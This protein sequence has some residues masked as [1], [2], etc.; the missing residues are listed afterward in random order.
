MTG[1]DSTGQ[2]PLARQGWRLVV[3]AVG[4]ASLVLALAIGHLVLAWRELEAGAIHQQAM[5]SRVLEGQTNNTLNAV[6]S[7]LQSIADALEKRTANVDPIQSG[8]LLSDMIERQAA[9]RSLSLL[10]WQGRVL[11]STT[12]DNI[13]LVIDFDK[14]GGRPGK[15]TETFGRWLPVRDLFQIG[16]GAAAPKGLG[17]IPLVSKVARAGQ[18]PLALVALL[19][20]DSLANQQALL[21]GDAAASQSALFSYDGQLLLSG[22]KVPFD[23]GSRP[24][25]LMPF[26]EFLPKQENGSYVGTGMDGTH[27]IGAFRTL[28]NWPFV[29]VS[30]RPYDELWQE[31]I[32]DLRW[33]ATAVVLAWLAIVGLAL[34]LR[35]GVRQELQS[36]QQLA[37]LHKSVASSEEL[38]KFALEGNGDGV[39]DWH[40]DT[41]AVQYSARA[42]AILGLPVEQTGES[43]EYFL[44]RVLAADREQVRAELEQHLEDRS[45]FIYTEA[46]VR[47]GPQQ[48]RWVLLRGMVTPERDRNARPVR[49]T[50][51]LTDITARRQAESALVS[52][53]ARRLAV[54]QSAMDAIITFGADGGVIDFNAAAQSMFGRTEAQAFKQ[55]MHEFVVPPHM[56]DSFVIELSIF[57]ETGS[58]R[59]VNR[60]IETESMRADGSLFPVELTIVPVRSGDDQLFT[61][62]LR[63]ISGRRRAEQ[64]LRDSEAR[65]QATF[66]QVAVGVVEHDASLQLVRV[67]KPLCDLLGYMR[68]ELLALRAE[69]MLHPDDIEGVRQGLRELLDGHITHFI[70]EIRYRRKDGHY[71]W[72]R[73]TAS[74]VDNAVEHTR[75]AV[76][77]VE[78]ISI[79]RKAQ[80]ELGAARKR[81]LQIGTRIQQSLLVTEPVHALSGVRLSSFNQASQDVDG[82]FFEVM[83]PGTDVLDLIAGDVMGKGMNAALMGAAVK[84]QFS[85]S[86]V[87]LLKPDAG[88]DAT[89]ATPA[90]VLNAV[91]RAMTPHLQALEAF[92]T[93][94]YVRIDLRNKTLTWVGCGH[95]EAVLART[96]GGLV[97]LK[98]QQPPLGVLTNAVFVQE[99]IPLT[100]GDTLLLHSDGVSDALRD[101]GE[102]VGHDRIHTT[103]GRLVCT[104]TSPT[105]MLHLMR[106]KLLR[107]STLTDDVTIVMARIDESDPTAQRLELAAQASSIARLRTL[108]ER[109]VMLSGID[110]SEGG[111]FVVA[112]IEA[113]TNVCRHAR[114]LVDG[115]PVEVQTRR[116]TR[117]WV[118]EL[119]YVGDA[120]EPPETLA[121]TSF[122]EYPEGGFGLAIIARACDQCDYLHHA[123]VNTTRLMRWLGG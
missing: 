43:I 26:K 42:R 44:V 68:D 111:L 115:A 35:R 102:R 103:F 6:V 108:L 13:D 83:Q 32:P 100:V 29:V 65:A 27:S 74:P 104:H 112:V 4:I 54:L 39:W 118:V 40:I 58:S 120:Y 16:Q 64:A 50:G 90:D 70:Q 23:G 107:T 60:R 28:R 119:T 61:A 22:A 117:E 9:L 49:L 8:E 116:T 57:G 2:D 75:F 101:N 94:C 14:I 18:A 15:Q 88:H 55:P 20:P 80:D 92:V 91:H 53:Q 33:T 105:A 79:Q 25:G 99:T 48:F 69:D 37:A 72:V 123:G 73:L 67:N 84:M 24:E 122:D 78:D 38:W 19:N 17:V 98:N 36:Q 81:E 56:R 34:A 5:Y 89:P 77:I 7:H 11:A 10:D 95:E 85:R 82:D 87:E 41:G 45:P 51:T 46:R 86:L 113:F 71:L 93:L 12:L 109:E 62:T 47:S 121:L 52:S 21:I 97:L 96:D 30:E 66:E 59:L 110:E 63:D 3:A 76:G 1:T 31:L 114:G 106:Q